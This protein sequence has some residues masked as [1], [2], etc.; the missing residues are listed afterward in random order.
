MTINFCV[1]YMYENPK[2]VKILS[3][4]MQH[5]EATHSQWYEGVALRKDMLDVVQRINKDLSSRK[6]H[7]RNTKQVH[8][9][10]GTDY[11]THTVSEKWPPTQQRNTLT[12]KTKATEYIQFHKHIL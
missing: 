4:K 5:T 10:P 8:C 11:N 3:A 2:F 1:Q 9:T 12:C 6:L 7:I